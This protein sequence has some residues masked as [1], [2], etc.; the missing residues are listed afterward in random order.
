MDFVFF[1]QIFQL[2]YLDLICLIFWNIFFDDAYGRR[3]WKGHIDWKSKYET[4]E[5]MTRK[6][7]RERE[8]VLSPLE[9]MARVWFFIMDLFIMKYKNKI[10]D[11]T[12]T[13]TCIWCLWRPLIRSCT[14]STIYSLS[15]HHYLC[16]WHKHSTNNDSDNECRMWCSFAKWLGSHPNCDSILFKKKIKI[17][18]NK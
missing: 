9:S 4:K 14:I 17:K 10:N 13:S 2:I 7:E 5:K 3:S 15:D 12:L 8:R 18:L 6:K 11:Q 16:E 1:F